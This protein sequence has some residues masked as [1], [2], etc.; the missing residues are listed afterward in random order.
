[1]TGERWKNVLSVLA[2]VV[3]FLVALALAGGALVMSL[4]GLFGDECSSSEDLAI[5]LLLLGSVGV[6]L[7]VPASVA[8]VRRQARWLLAPVI[9][10]GLIAGFFGSI[11]WF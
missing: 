11:T 2:L 5:S 8:V 9:E 7:L 3:G 4:C 10:V 1:M 6:F